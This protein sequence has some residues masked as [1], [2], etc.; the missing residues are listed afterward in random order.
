VT[1]ILDCII[2]TTLIL[3]LALLILRL[4]RGKS[5]A[6]RHGVLSAAIISGAL[7]PVFS[8]A[9]RSWHPVPVFPSH[10]F[11]NDAPSASIPA[12]AAVH[13]TSSTIVPTAL[14]IW[15][16]GV[17]VGAC[18]IA[19]GWLRLVWI[20]RRSHPVE[21]DAWTRQATSIASAYRI[22]QPIPL[23]L[24]ADAS[25]LVTWGI[26]RPKVI[27]PAG[28][29]DW[30]EDRI[31]AVL[32]HEFV[33]IRRHDL[34]AQM[35]GQ[36]LRVVYWFNPLVWA[37][38]SQLCLES[39]CACDDAV[40]AAG[41][42]P[43]EYAGHLVEVARLLQ[44]SGPAWSSALAMAAPSTIERR[45]AAMLS[46]GVNRRPI[47][48]AAMAA[49][50]IGVVVVVAPLAMLSSQ[51][52]PVQENSS[53]TAAQPQPP[54]ELQRAAE[55]SP[56]DESRKAESALQRAREEA[57][58]AKAIV[59]QRRE[60]ELQENVRALEAKQQELQARQAEAL[61]DRDE[62][63][64]RAIAL[65]DLERLQRELQNSRPEIERTDEFLRRA[66]AD[67]QKA[68]ERVQESTRSNRVD[69]EDLQREIRDMQSELKSLLEEVRALLENVR[70]E[71]N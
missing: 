8:F 60:T 35:L 5:A 21:A 23:L 27:L 63:F 44:Q 16:L 2:K 6:F 71:K 1:I 9:M 26:A 66:L 68:L 17:I 62:L 34:V 56:P 53:K 46:T 70:R 57:E 3:A 14:V 28:A 24:S 40:L 11:V 25:M 37:V 32:R 51:P 58:R 18:S 59:R 12:S 38:C 13:G 10:V 45:F 64:E 55:Q 22:R 30:P 69:T 31:E 49:I 50:A 7:V 39:E 19:A 67:R 33:H 42:E 61:R 65:R 4:L 54:T 52:V 20:T 41:I 47:S 15:I 36:A 29:E 43:H 48:R